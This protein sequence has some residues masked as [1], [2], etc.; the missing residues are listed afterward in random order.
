MKTITATKNGISINYEIRS[1][2]SSFIKYDEANQ[3]QQSTRSEN[4]FEMNVIQ[5]NMYRRLFYGME[6]FS[7][8]EVKTMSKI[9]ISKISRDH[10]KATKIVNQLKYQKYFGDYNKLLSVLFPHV[11]LDFYKDGQDVS[12]PSLKELKITTVDIIDKW[13]EEKLLP[14]NFY[15]L[16]IANL[17]L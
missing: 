15:N 13:V 4:F 10:S 8:E 1:K 17:A 6:A 12:L 3:Q 9:D 5:R 7:A 11:K 16:N 2:K 14:S